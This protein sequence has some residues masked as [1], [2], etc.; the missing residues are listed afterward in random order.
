MSVTIERMFSTAKLLLTISRPRFYSYLFGP[1]LIGGAAAFSNPLQIMDI[2]FLLFL[3]YFILPANIFLYGV[4]DIFDT[5]TDAQ[6]PKKGSREHLLKQQEKSPLFFATLSIVVLTV[7]CLLFA[8]TT[9]AVLLITF[10][11]LSWGYSAPPL[12]FKARPFWDAYSNVLY[13]F[14][15]FFAYALFTGHLPTMPVVLMG[16]TWSA[17]MHAFSAIPDMTVDK[18][19]GIATTA[20]YLGTNN[21]LLFILANWLV[22]SLVCLYYFGILGI[23]GWIPFGIALYIFLKKKRTADFYWYFPY[24]IPTLGFIAFWYIMITRFGW[25]QLWQL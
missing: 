5:E 25:E 9:A 20:V 3:L 13:A 8:Q 15:G 24:I 17:G 1:F 23:L 6:N 16:L 14:P 21:T 19:A 12:R 22:F 2:K 10:L 4:N 7:A 11:F 18:K